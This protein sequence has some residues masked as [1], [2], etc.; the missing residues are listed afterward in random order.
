[1]NW[2]AVGSPTP[3]RPTVCEPY[4]VERSTPVAR[5][6][7]A[8]ATIRALWDSVGQPVRR[9]SEFFPLHDV[10]RT[11]HNGSRA[12]S[13]RAPWICR[14]PPTVLGAFGDG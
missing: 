4:G 6:K 11:T 5:L 1:M 13:H 10:R 14:R 9:D 2:S 7:E 3:T 12:R 8:V